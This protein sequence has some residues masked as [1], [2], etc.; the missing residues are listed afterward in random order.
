MEHFDF[1]IGG[2]RQ[3]ISRTLSRDPGNVG[4]S[5]VLFVL[6]AMNQISFFFKRGAISKDPV[7]SP[8]TRAG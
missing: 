2:D 6:H 1:A 5:D 7:H 8:P 4:G 3:H